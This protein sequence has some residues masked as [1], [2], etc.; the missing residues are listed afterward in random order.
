MRISVRAAIGVDCAAGDVHIAN[1]I[2]AVAII[3]IS[4]RVAI[5]VDCAAGDGYVAFGINAVAIGRRLLISRFAADHIE[6]AGTGDGQ[7]TLSVNA[8]ACA[9]T[10]VAAG[11]GVFTFQDDV[12]AIGQF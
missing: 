7:A 12:R 10:R 4:G 9:A 3:R 1:C 5:G 2:D 6:C 11:D 8:V